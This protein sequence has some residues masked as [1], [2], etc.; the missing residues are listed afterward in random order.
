MKTK[1]VHHLPYQR[2]I[3]PRLQLAPTLSVQQI[4]VIYIKGKTALRIYPS[5]AFVYARD[6]I[7]MVD[8]KRDYI[9]VNTGSSVER[10]DLFSA[11]ECLLRKEIYP[12]NSSKDEPMSTAQDKIFRTSPEQMPKRPS[13]AFMIYSSTLRKRIKST[14]PEYTNSDISKLLGAMWKNAGSDVKKEY[15]EKANEVREWHKERYP[16]YEYN[17]RKT[18]KGRDSLIR[19]DLPCTNFMASEDEWIGQLNAL[20]SQNSATSLLTGTQEDIAIDFSFLPGFYS[21]PSNEMASG[22]L[23]IEEWKNMYNGV[24]DF[25][26]R[27]SDQ[28]VLLDESFWARF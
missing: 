21:P 7:T 1:Q 23:K 6:L 24:T 27:Y 28:N 15:M 12:D 10:K 5:Q 14:F 19:M 20:L 26:L 18:P 17:S 11:A 2:P 8:E 13:N 16:D 9:T 22:D 3:K 25:D 4:S